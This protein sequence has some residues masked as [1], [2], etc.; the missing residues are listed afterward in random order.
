MIP[1]T[2]IIYFAAAALLS[3]NVLTGCVVHGYVTAQWEAE[4]ESAANDA[5]REK[6]RLEAQYR[7]LEDARNEN[8]R[9]LEA[10]YAARLKTVDAERADFERRLTGRLRA[11]TNRADRCELSRAA[12]AS[13][14]PEE[15]EP[16]GNGQLGRIDPGAVSRVRTIGKETQELLVLCRKWANSVGR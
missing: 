5:L 15:P 11:Q 14:S 7:A 1:R 9:N 2:W 4:R 10:E 16:A 13:G 8:T 3:S 6:A 12:A